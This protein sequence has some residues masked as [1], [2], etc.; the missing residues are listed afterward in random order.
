VFILQENL[1]SSRSTLEQLFVAPM[2]F[3]T[4]GLGK[5]L[6]Y[7]LEVTITFTINFNTNDLQIKLKSICTNSKSNDLVG[8]K[9]TIW[10]YSTIKR[11]NLG[12]NI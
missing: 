1:C 7:L 8:K 10:G 12:K 4:R 2:Q 6:T 9:F 11:S 3:Y 5:F